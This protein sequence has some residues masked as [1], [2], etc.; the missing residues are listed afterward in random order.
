MPLAEPGAGGWVT[1][2]AAGET[3]GLFEG[4]GRS[5]SSSPRGLS[6]T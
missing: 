1:T 6:T 4:S 3:L 2:P 5:A